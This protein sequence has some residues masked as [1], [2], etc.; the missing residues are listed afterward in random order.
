MMPSLGSTLHG[1]AAPFA[2]GCDLPAQCR[3]GSNDGGSI[4]RQ[5]LLAMPLPRGSGLAS[6]SSRIEA[7][8]QEV[9]FNVKFHGPARLG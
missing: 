3:S 4:H 1:D 8:L 5:L 6:R 7:G 9:G 2:Q